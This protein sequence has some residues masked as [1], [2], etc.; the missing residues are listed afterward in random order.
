MQKRK[1]MAPR[2]RQPIDW[3]HLLHKYGM[4][5][6]KFGGLGLLV[7]LGYFI[8]VI[9]G[10]VLPS[11][12][13]DRAYYL[14]SSFGTGLIISA[15]VFA[16]GILLLTMEELAY[17]VLVGVGGLLL[18]F[19]IPYAVAGQ[20]SGVGEGL[21]AVARAVSTSGTNAGLAVLAVVG[22]RIVYEIYLQF[23]DA[24]ERR[25]QREEKQAAEDA[26]V[27]KKHKTIKPT[28]VLSPCWE[29]PFCH[30][31]IREVCPAFKARKPCWRYGIGCNCDP[32]MIDTLIR[33]GSPGKGP[34]DSDMR[35]REA[36]YIRS[37]L[38][39]D[40]AMSRKEDR[41]IPCSRCAI[42]G[43]HQRLKFK[44]LNPAAI[45][46]TVVAMGALY[47]PITKAWGAV[48]QG[49]VQVA[50]NITLHAEF[51][52]GTWFEYLQDDVVKVFFFI[53]VTLLALSYVLK[54]TEWVVLEKKL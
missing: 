27:L 37:D 52:A 48:A 42:Y 10:G 1:P 54:L 53:I 5:L 33:M 7:C 35:R 23:K 16:L 41:T 4:A 44:F 28:T 50:K 19:G 17:A 9:Y 8:Y 14:V 30:E 6:T 49:I 46:G 32:K 11:A 13:A 51:D 18:M 38:E 39:A 25:R 15:L 29:L 26:G 3:G 31:R 21:Q 40:A 36:A 24:P 47:L 34:Q 22:V 45:L 43:E 20:L 12:D 2:D